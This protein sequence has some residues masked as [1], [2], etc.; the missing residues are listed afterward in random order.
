MLFQRGTDRVILNLVKFSHM[1][2][3]TSNQKKTEHMIS[4]C[5]K[6]SWQKR[7][8]WDWFQEIISL[9]HLSGHKGLMVEI[10][11]HLAH[12]WDDAGLVRLYL[13]SLFLEQEAH[14]A[15]LVVMLW[16]S[17]VPNGFEPENIDTVL[18]QSH[19]IL[20]NLQNGFSGFKSTGGAVLLK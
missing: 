2:I 3:V 17:G 11:H 14:Q 7:T 12:A 4:G 5:N 18:H 16:H 9:Q 8:F 1:S 15:L 13:L 20:P 6:L 10:W 19:Q